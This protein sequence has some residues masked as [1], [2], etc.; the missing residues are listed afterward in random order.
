MKMSHLNT[1]EKLSPV[2][3]V[4][5]ANLAHTYGTAKK[6]G[7]KPHIDFEAFKILIKN[8]D[9]NCHVRFFLPAIWNN[10]Q[11]TL[12]EKYNYSFSNLDEL[13]KHNHRITWVP[14]SINDD[15]CAINWAISQDKQGYKVILISSDRFRNLLTDKDLQ[16]E[17]ADFLKMSLVSITFVPKN[18]DTNELTIQADP[19]D[20][21]LM[22]MS[23][24]KAAFGEQLR[25]YSPNSKDK[26]KALIGLNAN[27]ERNRS[28]SFSPRRKTESTNKR[29]LSANPRINSSLNEERELRK[30][31]IN[32]IN[33]NRPYSNIINRERGRSRTPR[34]SRSPRRRTPSP[35]RRSRSPRR[36]SRSPR[37]REIYPNR[38][39]ITRSVMCKFFVKGICQRGNSCN[40]RH[41][42]NSKLKWKTKICKNYEFGYC[43]FNRNECLF[44]HGMS[45]LRR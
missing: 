2:V 38:N 4:D 43:K 8:L 24:F 31:C 9:R 6:G 3:V 20:S 25:V 13:L 40:F 17:I 35:R 21:S 26:E 42:Q 33:T 19:I 5:G 22:R 10:D 41:E 37:R 39:E 29:S 34:R 1:N 7:I 11:N 15:A 44:A 23:V 36:R 30:R 32:N 12:R 45:D 27:R 16:T 28:R 14:Q 18:I